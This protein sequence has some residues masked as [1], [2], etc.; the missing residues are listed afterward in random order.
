MVRGVRPFRGPTFL[1]FVSL[2]GLVAGVVAGPRV[3]VLAN[4]DD[5]E[6]LEVA[7]HYVERRGLGERAIVALPMPLTEEIT[8]PEF[9]RAIWNPLL[10][11]AIDRGAI[12]AI[13]MR[14]TDELGRTKIAA[15]GHRLDA[16]VVCRGVPL[17]VAHDPA[18]F[19]ERSNPLAANPVLRTNEG[20]VDS[21][22]TLLA[23]NGAPIAAL[24]PN[25]VHA[26]GAAPS[27]DD[28][29]RQIIPVGR[30]DGPTAADAK[31]LVDRA[32]EAERHGLWG[33]AYVDIGGPHR[34]GDEWLEG[35]VPELTALGFETDVDRERDT[36]GA[37][38][39]FDAPVLYFG[40]YAGGINGPFAAP[41]FRFPPGAIALHI[42]SFSATTLRS[43]ARGWTGPL[44]ARGVTATVGNV[45]E[46]Y[47]QF[48]HQPHLLLRAL[49][50]GE[51]LGV[52]A[53]RSVNALSWKAILVGDPL[54]RPFA[55]AAD[56]QWERRAD[57]PT[58]AEPYARIRRMRMLAA[59]GRGEEALALGAAGMR[60]N[61]S[62]PLALT[63]AGM[64]LSAGDAVSARRTLGV[65][66]VMP[67]WRPA[68][69]PLVVAA[70]Q[71]LQAAGAAP[72]GVK[73]IER[74]LGEADLEATFRVATLK[75]GAA[76]ARAANDFTRAG[77]WDAEHQR[78]TAP[79]PPATP[80]SSRPAATDAR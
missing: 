54:Y 78:M 75:Q 70:A 14:L 65:F 25:P 17:R 46:P 4:A 35:C 15:A 80:A 37:H 6:S 38:A 32:L 8:W 63:L 62:L 22:L 67:R 51:P 49:M 52:A 50:R 56:A 16:L 30:L 28:P 72:E 73:L 40:W 44:V 36:L 26:A 48:T 47:L 7:R 12:D 77:R 21:E 61:P 39:R 18:L 13:A 31:A 58:E 19:D 55:V 53:L 41:G 60:Q 11:E 74:L 34:Q 3:L 59:A 69:R 1:L 57:L 23:Q 2:F 43:S 71:A 5:P 68:D 66:A 20:A 42:H 79:S 9:I 76:L 10:N 45:A 27:L 29:L 24:V 64:Q 33:R